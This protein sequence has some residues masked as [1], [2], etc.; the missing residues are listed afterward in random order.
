MDSFLERIQR[1]G[2]LDSRG[3]F[4]INVEKAQVKLSS[5]Q[6]ADFSQFPTFLLGAGQAANASQLLLTFP[7][8]GGIGASRSTRIEF[9]NWTLDIEDLRL[10]GLESLKK[11]TPRPIRYLATILSTLGANQ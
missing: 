1:E 8:L 4:T 5:F 7:S 3:V 11:E 10:I 9:R 6:L 2:A